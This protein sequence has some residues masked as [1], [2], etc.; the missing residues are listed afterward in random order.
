MTTLVCQNDWARPFRG[1]TLEI[2]RILSAKGN[3]F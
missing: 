3:E 2:R 1:E